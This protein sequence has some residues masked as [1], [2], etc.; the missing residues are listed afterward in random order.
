MDRSH[1]LTVGAV[2]TPIKNYTDGSWFINGY[3]GKSFGLQASIEPIGDFRSDLGHY[4]Q[5]GDNKK[6]QYWRVGPRVG[7]SLGSDNPWV[8]LQLTA[9]EVYLYGVTG[10]LSRVD[11]FKS[12]LSYKVLKVA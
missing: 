5:D 3:R 6:T 7:F 9:T 1:L 4:T 10:A 11:Y 8:P 12:V 2:Y